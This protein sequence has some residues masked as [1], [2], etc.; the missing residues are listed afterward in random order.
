MPRNMSF[1]MITDQILCGTKTVTRRF[2][3]WWLRP[4]DRLWDETDA[5]SEEA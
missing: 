4:G 5:P 1:S 2:G 3:W